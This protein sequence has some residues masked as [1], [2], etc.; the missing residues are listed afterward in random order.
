VSLLEIDVVA[1]TNGVLRLEL[2]GEIDL[3]SA[4]GLLDSLLSAALASDHAQVVIDLRH[5]TFIDSCGLGAIVE[6]HRRL[7]LD[8]SHLVIVRPSGLVRRLFE[9][10]GLDSMLDL[11]PDWS[12]ADGAARGPTA[13]VDLRGRA[14]R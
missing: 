7:A 14:A 5:V 13:G 4:P 3:S 12:D 2:G 1:A 9:T 10:T 11:R 6:T 8:G